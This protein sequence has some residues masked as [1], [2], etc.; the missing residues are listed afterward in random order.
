MEFYCHLC[1]DW[2]DTSYCEAH[3]ASAHG[4]PGV[5]LEKAKKR[6]SAVAGGLDIRDE[7]QIADYSDDERS[8]FITNNFRHSL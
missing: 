2:I 8:V 7:K 5:T 1:L 6:M 3:F 4:S